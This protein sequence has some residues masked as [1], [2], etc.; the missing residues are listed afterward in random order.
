[1]RGTPTGCMK[2]RTLPI[3]LLVAATCAVYGRILGHGFIF[4]WDDNRY[5][6]DNPAIRGFSWSHL[7]ELFTTCYVGNYAPV[8]MLSYLLDYRIWGLAAG[9]F[10]FTN[11]LIHLANGLL[12]YR[13]LLRWYADRGLAL[14]AA[15]LFL[16]HPV[17]VESVAWVS[18]RKNLLAM[19]LFLLA[20]GWYCRYREA[21]EGAGRRP[22][23]ASVVAFGA[24]LLAKSVTVILPLVLFL[25]DLSFPGAGRRLRVK[26]KLP[27]LVLAGAVGALTVYVQRAEFGGGRA[28]FPGGGPLATFCTMLTVFCRYLG[29]VVWPVGLSAV[30]APPIHQGP[31]R[32]VLLA[33]LLLCGVGTAGWLLSRRDRRLGF[34]TAFFFVGLLPVSQIVPLVTLMNDRYLYFPMLGAAALFG[35]G[36]AALRERFGRYPALAAAVVPL[37]FLALL[38]SERAAVWHDP[39]ALWSDAVA[40]SPT[41]SYAWSS[42]AEVYF[43]DLRVTEA[44]SAYEKSLALDPQNRMAIAAL[45]PI[46]TEMGDLDRGAA[47]LRRFLALRPDDVKAW[48]YLGINDE[49]RGDLPGAERMYRRALAIR[50]DSRQALFLLGNLAIERRRYDEAR[51]IFRKAAGMWRNDPEVTYRLACVAAL[52][53]RTDEAL[54]LL[55]TALREGYRDD[56]LYDNRELSSLWQEPRFTMLMNRYFP[57]GGQTQ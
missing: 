18:Q 41:A 3:L 43:R 28:G 9:G 4:N 27:Y 5:V 23:A 2:S 1:M 45:G 6:I 17:Q 40:K 34:W 52:S 13:L 33:A 26:D 25:H 42:L 32:T 8:Q 55:E 24:S 51:D 53:G 35:A 16:L 56:A 21:R 54:D 20:W 14:A 29:M 38:G 47:M 22:Y 19:L 49:K 7:R 46:Y 31:D 12:F 50:P 11:I 15:A 57:A 30:Y 48:G 37:L 39:L 10:L 44:V 36:I